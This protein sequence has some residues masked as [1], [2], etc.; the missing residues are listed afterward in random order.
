MPST[1]NIYGYKLVTCIEL[2]IGS[3][4]FF[5]VKFMKFVV[6][7]RYVRSAEE[8]NS[9]KLCQFS[10]IFSTFSVLFCFVF[11][12]ELYILYEC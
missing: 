3:A 12:Q 1:C 8:F 5:S 7:L 10:Y 6:S 11:E 4:F 2:S 9:L